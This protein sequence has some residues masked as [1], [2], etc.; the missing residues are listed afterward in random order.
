MMVFYLR[1]SSIGTYDQCPHKYFLSYV[2]GEPEKPRQKTVMGS[3]YHKIMENLALGRKAELAGKKSYISEDFGRIKLPIDLD[4]ITNLS[5]F[6]YKK[7]HPEFDW[8]SVDTKGKYG[9]INHLA[10]IRSW[11]DLGLDMVDPRELNVK[12]VEVQFDIPIEQD[13]ANYSYKL[14]GETHEGKLSLKGTIDLVVEDDIIQIIDWKTGQRKNWVTGEAKEYEHFH[15]DKQLLLYY[16]VAHH[17]YPG[18]PIMMNLVWVNSG[19]PFTIYF[20]E[21]DY[22]RAEEMIKESFIKI[23]NQTTAKLIRPHDF[24]RFCDFNKTYYDQPKLFN[25]GNPMNKCYHIRQEIYQIGM[26]QTIEKYVKNDGKHLKMY[27]EGGG[28]DAKFGT[29]SK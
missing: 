25:D 2:L 17:L 27:S 11:V 14:L 12:D 9:I 18:K 28:R 22:I 23:K 26:N 4:K 16:Y 10:D 6:L 24:C 7:K 3:I 5:F 8:I 15:K 20:D 21:S 19:G 13:W 1:S 29:E